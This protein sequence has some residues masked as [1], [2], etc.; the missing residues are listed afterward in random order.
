[1]IIVL[2]HIDTYP[3]VGLNY[4]KDWTNTVIIKMEGHRIPYGNMFYMLQLE[5]RNM[6]SVI[7]SKLIL[8]PELKS[9]TQNVQRI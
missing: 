3:H 7:I 1:M 8:L 6:Q 4:R 5:I 9:T 2:Y